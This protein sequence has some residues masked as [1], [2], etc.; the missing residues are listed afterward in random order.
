V[1]PSWV[2]WAVLG[3]CA[4]LIVILEWTERKQ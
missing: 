4:I 3:V 2:I 1:S